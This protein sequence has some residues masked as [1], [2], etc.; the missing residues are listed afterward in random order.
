MTNER[1]YNDIYQIRERLR[2]NRIDHIGYEPILEGKEGQK[3][4]RGIY[5]PNQTTYQP[6]TSDKRKLI[7]QKHIMGK[8]AEFKEF[9]RPGPSKENSDLP[10][11]QIENIYE[12]IEKNR[13]KQLVEIK[14]EN[15][16]Q[17]TMQKQKTLK[18]QKKRDKNSRT[19]TAE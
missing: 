17:E 10:E 1:K 3:Y 7:I 9:R 13:P 4:Y 15:R 6:L 8:H 11:L 5:K 2:R 18:E 19:T 16:V 14:M 12:F